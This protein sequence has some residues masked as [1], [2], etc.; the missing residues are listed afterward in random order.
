MPKHILLF[1][2]KIKCNMIQSRD[3]AVKQK[4]AFSE[5]GVAFSESRAAAIKTVQKFQDASKSQNHGVVQGMKTELHGIKDSLFQ[6]S[7]ESESTATPR[8]HLQLSV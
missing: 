8:N 7:W 6:F 2:A 3:A 4:A 1:T 5:P